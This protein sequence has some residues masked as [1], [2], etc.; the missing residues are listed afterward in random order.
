MKK[1]ISERTQKNSVVSKKKNKQTEA[2][3]KHDLP[4]LP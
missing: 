3:G 2:S 4:D 1:N